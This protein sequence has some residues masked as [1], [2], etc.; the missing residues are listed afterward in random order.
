MRYVRTRRKTEAACNHTT[1]IS[2]FV[3]QHLK[4]KAEKMAISCQYTKYNRGKEDQSK[5]RADE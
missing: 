1:I 4:D 5:Q 2:M 3:V